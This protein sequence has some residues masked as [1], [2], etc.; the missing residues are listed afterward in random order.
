MAAL[1]ARGINLIMVLVAQVQLQKMA[2]L[3]AREIN[4]TKVLAVLASMQITALAE[5]VL[6]AS[7][8]VLVAYA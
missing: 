7:S 4:L 2:A 6:L 3:A 8:L 5:Q 1:A